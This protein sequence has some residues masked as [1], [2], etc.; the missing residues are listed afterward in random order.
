MSGLAGAHH[1]SHL[2]HIIMKA[3]GLYG[4]SHTQ[5]LRK[6]MSLLKS[7]PPCTLCSVK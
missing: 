7:Y 5:Y 3:S 6:D 4:S 1:S 2:E